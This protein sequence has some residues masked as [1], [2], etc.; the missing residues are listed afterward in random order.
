MTQ[1][2]RDPPAIAGVHLVKTTSRE[3]DSLASDVMDIVQESLRGGTDTDTGGVDTEYQ[4]TLE[5]DQAKRT[6]AEFFRAIADRLKLRVGDW[7]NGK[8]GLACGDLGERNGWRFGLY[9]RDGRLFEIEVLYSEIAAVAAMQRSADLSN[10]EHVLDR[11]VAKFQEAR[12]VWF[13]RRDGV[14]LQ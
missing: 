10:F 5:A 12:R 8:K 3:E 6:E 4:T 2:H 1:Q 11:I 14:T 7:A 9:D 13:A